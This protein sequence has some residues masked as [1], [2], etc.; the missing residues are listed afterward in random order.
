[1]LSMF[2]DCGI[3]IN[4]MYKSTKSYSI[5]YEI[6]SG[7]EFSASVWDLYPTCNKRKMG[8]YIFVVIILLYKRSDSKE[9]AC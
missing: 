9:L 1:M 8:S 2:Y 3:A 4:T 6:P 7:K 5:C